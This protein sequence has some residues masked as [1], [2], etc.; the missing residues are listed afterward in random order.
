MYG[1]ASS[2]ASAAGHAQ[3][4]GLVIIVAII[5]LVATSRKDK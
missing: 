4:V 5:L 3:G 1:L 2:A